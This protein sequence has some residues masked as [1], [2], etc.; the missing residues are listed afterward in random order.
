MPILAITRALPLWGRPPICTIALRL[1]AGPCDIIDIRAQVAWSLALRLRPVYRYRD[2]SAQQ[3]EQLI[4]YIV[5]DGRFQ[6][7]EHAERFVLELDQRVALSYG[8]EMNTGTHHVQGINMIHPQAVY[9][10][11]GVGTLMVPASRHTTPRVF[12]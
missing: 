9:N 11:Q 7:L 2:V 3:L 1:A 8:T 12:C 5:L 6:V 10:L 4:Y